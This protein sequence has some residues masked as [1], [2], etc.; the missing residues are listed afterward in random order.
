MLTTRLSELG[1]SGFCFPKSIVIRP[2][3]PHSI[4][5]STEPDLGTFSTLTEA[6][7]ALSDQ[8]DYFRIR[9]HGPHSAVSTDRAWSSVG[10]NKTL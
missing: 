5:H 7:R 10:S 8:V 1:Q 4:I 3:S 2:E 9:W 6:E